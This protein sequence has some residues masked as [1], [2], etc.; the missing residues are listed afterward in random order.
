MLY[1]ATV[2]ASSSN[3][4][5]PKVLK[6]LVGLGSILFP[7]YQDP[8]IQAHI[9][10]LHE[11]VGSIPNITFGSAGNNGGGGGHLVSVSAIQMEMQ[12]V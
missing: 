11:A 12:G 8:M 2:A 4:Q 10:Q 5:V 9:D 6:Q 3:V 7:V 1:Q